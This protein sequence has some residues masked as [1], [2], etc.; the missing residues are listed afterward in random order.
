MKKSDAV[1]IVGTF[2]II[3]KERRE[4]LSELMVEAV[5]YGDPETAQTLKLLITDVDAS[6]AML[7]KAFAFVNARTG[8]DFDLRWSHDAITGIIRDCS[9]AVHS[10]ELMYDEALKAFVPKRGER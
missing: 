10:G 5:E 6:G 7:A 2:L 3:L 8:Q 1:A 9:V 4:E